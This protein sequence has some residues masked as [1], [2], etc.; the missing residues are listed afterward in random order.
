[1][2]TASIVTVLPFT[3][4]FPLRNAKNTLHQY[5]IFYQDSQDENMIG[6]ID[7]NAGNLTSVKRALDYLTIHSVIL[8]DPDRLAKCERIIFP[9]VGNAASAMK[10]LKE[11]GLDKMLQSAF[12]RGTPILGICLGAQIILSN[13]EEGN[14]ECLGLINGLCKKLEVR[15][16]TLKIPHMGWNEISVV[17]Q[18]YMLSDLG[19][20]SQVYFVHS[21]FPSPSDRSMIFATCEYDAVFPC[22]IGSKNLFATQFHLEKSGPVGLAMLKKFASWDGSQC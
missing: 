3:V 22:A 8:S 4:P 15:D 2:L 9:G 1:L 16:R 7:Y 12:S 6:I 17:S 5:S 21:Y 20:G 13:S 18:H 14:T 19:P 11:R 10:T